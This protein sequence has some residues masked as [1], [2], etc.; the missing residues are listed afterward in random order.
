MLS[1]IQFPPSVSVLQKQTN[2]I[3]EFIRQNTS[4][5]YRVTPPKIIVTHKV[6]PHR[7]STNK[8][9]YLPLYN[10]LSS[11]QKQTFSYLF[12]DN[13]DINS[14]HLLY[15]YCMIRELF[16]IMLEINQLTQQYPNQWMRDFIANLCTFQYYKHFQV[17]TLMKS[18]LFQAQ[19]QIYNHLLSKK[20]QTIGTGSYQH[21]IQYMDRHTIQTLHKHP[22]FYLYLQLSMMSMIQKLPHSYSLTTIFHHPDSLQT[23]ILSLVKKR[24]HTTM[25]LPTL[26]TPSYIFQII[27]RLLLISC[28]IVTI[29]LLFMVYRYFQEQFPN[30]DTVII[31]F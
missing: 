16:S 7:S 19:Q 14:H 26:D 25:S 1:A 21:Q 6:I 23:S 11:Q 13:T 31:P 28:I 5:R 9:L 12:H 27:K 15:N 18:L 3:C 22:F 30:S 20:E 10:R 4:E 29:C 2:S 8:A 24:P 17:D